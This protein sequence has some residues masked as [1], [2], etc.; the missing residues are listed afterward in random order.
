M[1]VGGDDRE[2]PFWG[3]FTVTGTTSG[4]G[5]VMVPCHLEFCQGSGD[6]ELKQ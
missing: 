1:T 4:I 5:V 3:R 6:T 2:V